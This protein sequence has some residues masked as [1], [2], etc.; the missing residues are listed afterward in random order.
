MSVLKSVRDSARA[1]PSRGLYFP[2]RLR[3]RDADSRLALV[4]ARLAAADR[5]A[6][7]RLFLPRSRAGDAA[8]RRSRR[9]ARRRARLL[10][11]LR[12]A[13]ARS[14]PRRL[15]A[16]ARF[17]FHVGVRLPRQ[18]RAGRG[19]RDA[20]RLSSRRCSSAPISTRRART[21][22]ATASSSRPRPA[23]F[24]VVQIAGLIARRIVCFT[25]EGAHLGAGDRFGLIR[26]GS[27]VDV[28]LPAGRAHR[29]RA[30]QPLRRRRDG[31]RAI[32]GA[33]EPARQFRKS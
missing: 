31:D 23:T 14:R 21:T 6:L 10:R 12:R 4:A 30:R 2:R 7:V 1:D 22:S 29:R 15:A 17:D 8:A 25:Q 33:D 11:R 28:Y 9:G 19:P 26:F 32:V 5:D 20:H 24:G 13:A 16:A 18:S 3:R 27:R